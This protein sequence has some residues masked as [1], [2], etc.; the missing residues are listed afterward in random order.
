MY[1]RK[2]KS[3]GQMS[4]SGGFSREIHPVHEECGKKSKNLKKGVDK[5]R[6]FCYYKRALPVRDLKS[7]A[8]EGFEEIEEETLRVG[9]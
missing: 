8:G 4:S 3:H 7:L 5:G 2:R 9:A 6:G 1:F